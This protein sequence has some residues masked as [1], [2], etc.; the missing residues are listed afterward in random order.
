MDIIDGSG[1]EVF[2]F[3]SSKVFRTSVPDSPADGIGI[4]L[5][6]DD[7]KGFSGSSCDSVFRGL[8]GGL[9]KCEAEVAL[10]DAGGAAGVGTE[11]L[12]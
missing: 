4:C 10:S 6:D 9:C 7:D 3:A 11:D 12:L 5:D 1:F 2:I 8:G